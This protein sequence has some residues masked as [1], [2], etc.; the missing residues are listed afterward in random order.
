MYKRIKGKKFSRKTDQRRAFMRSLAVN[1]ILQEKI[2]TT[3]VRAH[4]AGSF[5]ERL[6]TKAKAGDLASRKALSSILPEV[7]CRKLVAVIAPR[8]KDRNGGYTRVALL[9]QR[10]KDGAPMAVVELLDR[11]ATVQISATKKD[12]KAAAKKIKKTAKAAKKQ[13]VKS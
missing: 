5:V 13:E 7:A 11:P 8:F 9:G 4:Q 10:L 2:Q 3:K 1:L 12:V 6:I